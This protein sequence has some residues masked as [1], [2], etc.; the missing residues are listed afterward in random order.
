MTRSMTHRHIFI[1][2]LEWMVL[3]PIE[4]GQ[5]RMYRREG[6]PVAFATWALVSEETEKRLASGMARLAPTEW[7]NGDRLWLVELLA[8]FGNTDAVLEDLKKTAFAGK[9]FK[10][11]RRGAD[12]VP[13]VEIVHGV[14]AASSQPAAA[15]TN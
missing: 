4:F 9:T 5:F 14:P 13:R 3:P 15:Q 6:M 11:H 1:A 2:D 10:L 7:R 8:P 12:G